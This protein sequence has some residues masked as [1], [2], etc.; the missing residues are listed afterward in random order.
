MSTLLK[1]VRDPRVDF[2]RGLALL[3]IFIDHV[4]GNL[5]GTL[6][7][8]NFGFSDA[9]EVFVLLA[10]F[11]A[12]LAYG[13]AF[14]RSG[15]ATGLRRVAARCARIYVFQVGLLVATLA[16]VQ[17]WDVQFGL[18]P[19]TLDPFLQNG[20]HQV[21]LGMMLHS[22]PSNLNI[23][24]LYILL[25]AVFPLLY[26]G[27]R[28]QA[29]VTLAASA[30]LWAA[31]NLAPRLNLTNWYDGQG[32][33][34]NPFAWQFLFVLGIVAARLYVAKGQIVPRIPLLLACGWAFLA[35]ALLAAA[36]WT[37]WGLEWRVLDLDPDK[38]TLAPLRVVNILAFFYVLMT[39][40][41]F[42]RLVRIPALR[43]I[44]IC[45]RHSLEVFS[46]GTVCSL[47]G[48]LVF[49]SFGTSWDMQLVV[50]GAG[51]FCM[52][53]VALVLE[54]RKQGWKLLDAMLPWGGGA[55]YPLKPPPQ[56]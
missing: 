3:T 23:L 17:F 50:N 12:M 4:R 22:L 7:L 9:A 14:Q 31:A 56:V 38:T 55:R 36:P 29:P 43:S 40:Q 51:F 48:H 1:A 53:A 26:L 47:V 30:A 11:S 25:L 20:A 54:R 21:K 8:R 19:R 2:L 34:F 41:W 15:A 16:V 42:N 52:I 28:C 35:F 32:W 10:G 49:R 33:Y 45:G 18:P 5:L 6:T 24:P 13:K 37:N 39:A 27:L 44:E 46:V